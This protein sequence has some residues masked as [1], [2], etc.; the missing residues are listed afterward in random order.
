MMTII[1]MSV[2]VVCCIDSLSDNVCVSV[3]LCIIPQ[4]K[5]FK[6]Q[7]LKPPKMEDDPNGR[8]PKWKTTKME[9]NQNRLT[10]QLYCNQ[11]ISQDYNHTYQLDTNQRYQMECRMVKGK[12][13][14]TKL[15]A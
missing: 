6:V 12:L 3:C 9:F 10:F 13:R 1:R 15:Q 14:L 8:R 2:S 4:G 11:P 7:E 5:T